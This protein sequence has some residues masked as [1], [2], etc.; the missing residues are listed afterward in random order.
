MKESL[1]FYPEMKL[2][3]IL[4]QR[5]VNL[6]YLPDVLTIGFNLSLPLNCCQS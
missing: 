4:V 6:E 5:I 3:K 2:V 1:Y